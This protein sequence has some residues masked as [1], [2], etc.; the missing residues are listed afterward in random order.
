MKTI[1]TLLLC[2]FLN[3]VFAQENTAL[4]CGDGIDND[5]DGLIDCADDDCIDLPNDGCTTCGLGNTFADTVIDY[6]AGCPNNQDTF[7]ESTL[8]VSDYVNESDGDKYLYMGEG[9]V[10]KLGFTNNLLTNSGDEDD[11]VFVFEVGGLVEDCTLAFR[12]ANSFTETQLLALGITDTNNDGFYE[13]GSVGGS[14]AGYDIDQALPEYGS[15]ELIFDAIELTDVVD[16]SCPATTPGAD[17]DAVCALSS[18][19]LSVYDILN[20][21]V[22]I[23][24]NPTNSDITIRFDNVKENT[25]ITVANILGQTIYSNYLKNTRVFSFSL[26]AEAGIY[27]VIIKADDSFFSQ[28]IIKE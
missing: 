27:L 10:L 18:E 7:P 17:I 2:F 12:P 6:I 3:F 24:P 20:Q 16:L 9:G 23:Y 25:E 26:E 1:S 4:T 11:D 8:G 14:T 15:G 19:P 5:G 28:R 21:S 22:K 13:F